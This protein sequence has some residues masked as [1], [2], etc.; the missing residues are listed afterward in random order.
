MVP[1]AGRSEMG[2]LFFTYTCILLLQVFTVGSAIPR[3]RTFM[4]WTS[5]F[6]L[7]IM[8]SFFWTLIVNALILFQFVEDGTKFTTQFIVGTSIAWIVGVTFMSLD[9]AMDI[10]KHHDGQ[11][12]GLFFMTL[13]IPAAAV[14]IYV[15]LVCLLVFRKLEEYKSLA[16]V[17]LALAMFSV[18]QLILFDASYEIAKRTSGRVNGSL[19]AIFFDLVSVAFVYKFWNSITDDTWGDCIF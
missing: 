2:M 3:S 1:C 5:A 4:V 7:G 17:A 11:S 12:P 15:L 19:F 18:S 6:H 16:Y 14:L 8:V 13:V 9:L 10:T